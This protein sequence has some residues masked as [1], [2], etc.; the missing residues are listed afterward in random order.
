MQ[1]R[2]RLCRCVRKQVAKTEVTLKLSLKDRVH[3][4]IHK[5]QGNNVM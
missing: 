5:R 1:V 4:A 2:L 3:H